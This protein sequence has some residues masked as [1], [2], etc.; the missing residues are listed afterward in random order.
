MAP[1]PERLIVSEAEEDLREWELLEHCACQSFHWLT[2]RTSEPP[3][4]GRCRP[5]HEFRMT[6]RK[7][8]F[9]AV[10]VRRFARNAHG[11]SPCAPFRVCSC[12]LKWSAGGGA[13]GV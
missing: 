5:W 10:W 1:E 11:R 3:E 4:C 6:A 2:R 8:R 9:R 12:R 13:G 7:L